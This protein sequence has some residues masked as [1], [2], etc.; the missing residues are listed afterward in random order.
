M[1]YELYKVLHLGGV[2]LLFC[3]LGGLFVYYAAGQGAAESKLR[4]VLVVGHGLAMVILLVAGFGLLAR[5]NMNGGWGLWVWLKL[6]I[7]LLAGASLAL[8]KRMPGKAK[9]FLMAFP[10]VGLGAAYLAI[11]KPG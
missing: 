7:W 11:Y 3:S 2:V 1:P 4:P 9:L 5:L 8:A 10:L 6:G